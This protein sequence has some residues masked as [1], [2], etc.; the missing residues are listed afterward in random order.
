MAMGLKAPLFLLS[1]TPNY[2]DAERC[3]CVQH[4]LSPSVVRG[5]YLQFLYENCTT[6]QNRFGMIPNVTGFK[7]YPDAAAFLADLPKVFYLPD[8]LVYDIE[9][10]LYPELTPRTL[11]VLRYD[12]R[13]HRMIASDIEY[14]HTV[15]YQG[16]V[17][18]DGRLR[19]GI[20]DTLIDHINAAGGTALVFCTHATVAYAV[21]ESLGLRGVDHWIVTGKTGAR[22]KDELIQAFLKDGGVMVGT[23]TLATGTDGMDKVCDT[24]IILDDTD[25]DA[26]RRQLIGRIMPRGEQADVSA[27]R[28]LRFVPF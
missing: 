4:I 6:E 18:Q 9:D 1:A 5:G 3:Y 20:T 23:A 10:V 8:D 17:N 25:D 11:E 14:R 13:N 21:S 27:K 19:R 26:L 24:L 2:N 7:D 15:R 28:V 16:L 22:S 12:E